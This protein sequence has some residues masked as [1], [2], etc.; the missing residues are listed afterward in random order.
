M[1]V[2]M[3]VPSKR[4]KDEVEVEERPHSWVKVEWNM[5]DIPGTIT[6]SGSPEMY[7]KLMALLKEFQATDIQFDSGPI[8]KKYIDGED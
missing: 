2:S 7:D 1:G 3:P 4:E 8:E 5:P 6:D